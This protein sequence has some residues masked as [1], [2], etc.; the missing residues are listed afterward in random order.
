MNKTLIATIIGVLVLGGIA[1][2]AYLYVQGVDSVTDSSGESTNTVPPLPPSDREGTGGEMIP[3]APPAEDEDEVR[4]SFA[5]VEQNNTPESC[6]TV[7]E[8]R[9]YDIT[10]FISQHPGGAGAIS[11]IC[12]QDGTTEF[13]GQASHSSSATQ[14]L[15]SLYIGIVE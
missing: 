7:I 10:S 9:V 6:W 11:S 3:P 8:G 15:E 1:V 5:E 14:Q 12:G 13:Q 2:A 4:I